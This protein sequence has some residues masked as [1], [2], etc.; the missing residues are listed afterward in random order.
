MHLF[1][2]GSSYMT[3]SLNKKPRPISGLRHVAL[4]CDNLTSCLEFYT[5]ILGME[6]EWQPDLDNIYL[7]SGSDNL[8]LHKAGDNF[9]ADNH[10]YLDHIGFILSTPDLVDEWYNYMLGHNIVMKTQPRTHRDG[11]RSFYCQDPDGRT[12]QMIYHPPIS[13]L[14]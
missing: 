8:A 11:A 3:D 12:V 9:R 13:G 10:Q 1:A 7:T 4:F 6:I 14:K 5:N 2:Y